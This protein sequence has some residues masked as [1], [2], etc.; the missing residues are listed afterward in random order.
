[1]HLSNI[2]VVGTYHDIFKPE[3]IYSNT[4]WEIRLRD[5]Q[6]YT[7]TLVDSVFSLNNNEAVTNTVA[8]GF[9]IYLKNK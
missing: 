7:R 3:Q 8:E 2:Y 1:M 6:Y 5:I 4:F 9:I